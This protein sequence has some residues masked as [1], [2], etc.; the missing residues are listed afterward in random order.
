M[1]MASEVP[2]KSVKVGREGWE[3]WQRG[4]VGGWCVG[5]WWAGVVG[6]RGEEQ[7]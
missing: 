3:W 4:D 6:V 7:R 1:G 2:R 5:L